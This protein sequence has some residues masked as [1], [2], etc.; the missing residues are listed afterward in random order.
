MGAAKLQD[1]PTAQAA[2]S[3]SLLCASF[4][5]DKKDEEELGELERRRQCTHSI[6]SVYCGDEFA[7]EVCYDTGEVYKRTL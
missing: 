5:N 1:T 3:S 4:C 6:D 2:A 7:H